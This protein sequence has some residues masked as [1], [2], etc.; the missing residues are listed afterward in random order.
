MLLFVSL[1]SRLVCS[2]TIPNSFHPN[3]KHTLPHELASRSCSSRF[4]SA[5]D[6]AVADFKN[7]V[8]AEVKRSFLKIKVS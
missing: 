4:P 5:P 8:L 2:N 7:R 6:T 3:R 1:A